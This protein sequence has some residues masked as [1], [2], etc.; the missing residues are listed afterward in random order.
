MRLI[1]VKT[2]A[3]EEYYGEN[4][5]SYAVLSHTWGSEE[6]TYQEWCSRKFSKTKAGY[7][8]IRSACKLAVDDEVNYLWCDTN[9]IDKSSSAELTEAINSMFAWY[10]DAVV[11]YAYLEDVEP[12]PSNAAHNAVS[13]KSSRWFTRGWTL[14]E[15]LAPEEV[16]LYSRR[17][18]KL[19]TKR[20]LAAIISDITRIPIHVLEG[21][22]L[23]SSSVAQKM[24]WLST[25]STTRVE[26]MAYCMLGIFD[27]NIPLLYGEGS[28]AFFRLQEEIIRVSNDSTIFCWSW[29]PEHVPKNWTSMLAPSP[30]L[31]QYAGDYVEALDFEPPAVYSMTN[32]GLSIDLPTVST[33]I[34]SLVILKVWRTDWCG[35]LRQAVALYHPHTST[36]WRRI[37]FPPNPIPVLSQPWF[38]KDRFLI[39]SRPRFP[40][41]GLSGAVTNIERYGILLVF[42][43]ID[44][45]GLDVMQLGGEWDAIRGIYFL[46]AAEGQ[47]DCFGLVSFSIGPSSRAGPD[48]KCRL[49]LIF[50]VE[51]NSLAN[52]KYAQFLYGIE[53]SSDSL[54]LE[55]SEAMWEQRRHLGND[56]RTALQNSISIRDSENW[57]RQEEWYNPIYVKEVD[58]TLCMGTRSESFSI[59]PTYGIQNCYVVKGDQRHFFTSENSSAG[60]LSEVESF[61]S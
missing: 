53:K 38:R 39:Q 50:A 43:G 33:S 29:I 51:S 47:Y 46:D 27:L 19:G 31:F 9:C 22:G 52:R 58:A 36:P 49:T 7:E 54:D 59:H 61:S 15:L 48:E 6:V 37:F 28:K 40:I 44:S 20:S 14:Q 10:R 45:S 41:Y 16:L 17:W 56:G 18:T 2:L 11:C 30:R 60:H 1:N 8:K 25:R 55:S 42:D 57:K 35:N 32:A 5:P 13:I 26:D 23:L 3:F 21:D 24:S 34:Y 12:S 4:I